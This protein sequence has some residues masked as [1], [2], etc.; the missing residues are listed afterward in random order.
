MK[1]N[2]QHNSI[3]NELGENNYKQG[4]IYPENIFQKKKKRQR[5]K[6]EFANIRS[7]QK[8]LLKDVLQAE[9]NELRKKEGLSCEKE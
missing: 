8:Q 3:F 4:F 5:N 7:S 1:S 6:I 9:V 2:S